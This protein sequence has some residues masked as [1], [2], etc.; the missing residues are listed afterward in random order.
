M[1]II[2]CLSGSYCEHDHSG[3]S[4]EDDNWFKHYIINK[5]EQ[6]TNIFW[7]YAKYDGIETYPMTGSFIGYNQPDHYYVGN[8]TSSNF[9]ISFGSNTN[10]VE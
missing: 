9:S 4:V 1:Y 8:T 5:K 3:F 7:K 2:N 6:T 10:N